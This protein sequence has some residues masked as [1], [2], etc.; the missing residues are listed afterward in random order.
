MP[1]I[2]KYLEKVVSVHSKNHPELKEVQNLFLMT[3]AELTAHMKKEEFMIFPYIR[4]MVHVKE[5]G[6]HLSKPVFGSIRNPIGVMELEHQAEG[7]RISRIREITM[8][9]QAPEDA[10]KTLEATLIMLKEFE[11]DLHVHIHLENNLLFPKAIMLE[12]ELSN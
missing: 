1:I 8:D 10:C 11:A 2:N 6:G 7:D 9:Y 5:T 4:N 12:Q 3:I